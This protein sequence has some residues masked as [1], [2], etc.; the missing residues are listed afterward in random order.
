M[1]CSTTARHD[2][3]EGH[4]SLNNMHTFFSLAGVTAYGEGQSSQLQME[5]QQL[6]DWNEDDP[7][8]SS[9]CKLPLAVQ[10]ASS[11]RLSVSGG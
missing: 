10:Q 4:E 11:E 6:P 2:A 8:V 5:L 1:P 7:A 9:S 3:A